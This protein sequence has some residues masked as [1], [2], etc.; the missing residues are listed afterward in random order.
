MSWLLAS[1]RRVFFAALGL[2][3]VLDVG[4]S[5]LARLGYAHPTAMWQPD[6]AV[7]ADL[8]WPPGADL[9]ADVPLGRRVYARRC[10]VCHG[11]DGRGNGPAAPSL[12][13]R[14]RDF[15]L[16]QFE[17][18]S[19]APDQPPTDDDL[20]SVVTNGLHA[21]AMPYWHDVLDTAEIRAV[22]EHVKR[23]SAAFDG[24]TPRPLHI[25]RRVSPDEAS[26]ARGRELYTS[27]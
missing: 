10:A 24:P 27:K 21:S 3:L 12:T 26:V 22:V 2:L 18:K 6:P 17:Y 13:P 4:R 14:P 19:T 25:P 9:A 11:P 8:T 7:Y 1:R 16:G 5:T 20:I 15:T 23:L